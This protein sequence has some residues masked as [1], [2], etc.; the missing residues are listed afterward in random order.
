MEIISITSPTPAK[1]GRTP[2]T[3][4]L[5]LLISCVLR[6]P[7]DSVRQ[8]GT[9]FT[10]RNPHKTPWEGHGRSEDALP[11]PP[12]DEAVLLPLNYLLGIPTP[13]P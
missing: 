5:I 2:A 10:L 9:N 12:Q 11:S 8:R 13:P 7:L 3:S 4:T 6:L 1:K